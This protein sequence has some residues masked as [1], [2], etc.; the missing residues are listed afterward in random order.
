[1]KT[2]KHI[3][4]LIA[5]IILIQT[6][7]ATNYSAYEGT[8]DSLN[9]GG[10]HIGYEACAIHSS[11]AGA[12][13]EEG[14]AG[15]DDIFG[16]D[17]YCG[18]SCAAE[19]YI[20]V[21]FA[22][23]TSWRININLAGVHLWGFVLA[24]DHTYSYLD[25]GAIP[26]SNTT[27]NVSCYSNIGYYFLNKGALGNLDWVV[28][29]SHSSVTYV[30][31]ED[32]VYSAGERVYMPV[33]SRF[34][35]CSGSTSLRDTSII[36]NSNTLLNLQSNGGP[37]YTNYRLSCTDYGTTWE[38]FYDFLKPE[39]S[40]DQTYS[41]GIVIEPLIPL[42]FT[43]IYP[44]SNTQLWYPTNT[45]I[46]F[47]LLVNQPTYVTEITWY[48]DG[49]LVDYS[50]NNYS[51]NGYYGSGTY[52]V[53]GKITDSTC[54]QELTANWTVLIGNVA[55]VKG[56]VTNVYNE[57]IPNAVIS[58]G[59]I[60]TTTTNSSGDY[61]FSNLSLGS[62]VTYSMYASADGYQ[63]GEQNAT[64]T[65]TQ[66]YETVFNRNF[67]LTGISTYGQVQIT[68][69]NYPTLTNLAGYT[70]D[71]YRSG[72]KVLTI[73]NGAITFN[74]TTTYYNA[75]NLGNPT[76]ITQ[77]PI[78][79]SYTAIITKTGYQDSGVTPYLS[80]NTW[81]QTDQYLKPI[82]LYLKQT[83]NFTQSANW[84]N[85]VPT[86]GSTINV[87][88]DNSLYV[89]GDIITD[90]NS[91]TLCL[92]YHKTGYSY[93]QQCY[94]SPFSGQATYGVWI[95]L[96]TN[97]AYDFYFLATSG[98]Q[99]F[100]SGTYYFNTIGT[101]TTTTTSLIF[102]STTTRVTTTIIITTSTTTT[103]LYTPINWTTTTIPAGTP[104]NPP[105]NCTNL[106]EKLYNG[107]VFH[108]AACPFITTL[109]VSLTYGLL[110]L[111][112]LLFTLKVTGNFAAT[113]IL[114]LLYTSAFL[115]ILPSPTINYL[116]VGIGITLGMGLYG[117]IAKK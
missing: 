99:Q 39:Y 62:N 7:Q 66:A 103:T 25:C 16:M 76:T 114:G 55:T 61:L 111:V 70:L 90:S 102:P 113:G 41:K 36:I 15:G 13:L 40:S 64:I 110:L 87:T 95:S 69:K 73:T 74:I 6:A 34:I 24:E 86:N 21:P 20:S 46:N 80:T 5:L 19:Q 29:L 4:S 14:T 35:N 26:V 53:Q 85:I 75:T 47:S 104:N 60:Y 44:T 1:M 52:Y 72:Q 93:N 45:Q 2:Q 107:D 32:I 43:S 98:T 105:Y 11:N 22:G 116:V 115:S 56:K 58:L 101:P 108:C 94:P 65:Y 100:N 117:L 109:G 79:Y 51:Y 54:N 31:I 57:P 88:L 23:N 67:R 68:A 37:D 59:G 33:V 30:T 27:A 10:P 18:T 63:Q 17:W 9:I 42:N 50:T 112:I 77:L 84:S 3:I 83:E 96:D 48:E 78:G 12:Y 89:A 106:T 91:Y 81:V 49:G 71:L 82:S 28:N 92:Y 8:T 97:T 38:W